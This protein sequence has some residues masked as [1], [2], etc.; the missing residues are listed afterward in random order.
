MPTGHQGPNKPRAVTSVPDLRSKTS[1]F[2]K[3]PAIHVQRFSRAIRASQTVV[4]PRGMVPIISFDG[5]FDHARIVKLIRERKA[6]LFELPQ[7]YAGKEVAVVLHLNNPNYPANYDL[8]MVFSLEEGWSLLAFLEK[9]GMRANRCI[10]TPEHAR[11]KGQIFADA[12]FRLMEEKENGQKYFDLSLPTGETDFNFIHSNL[13]DLLPLTGQTADEMAFGEL[14]FRFLV[15]P[16]GKIEAIKISD[17]RGAISEL[18]PKDQFPFLKTSRAHDSSVEIKARKTISN[19]ETLAMRQ[20]ELKFGLVHMGV[21]REFLEQG[22]GKSAFDF[23]QER[24]PPEM[25]NIL[26]NLSDEELNKW[27]DLLWKNPLFRGQAVTFLKYLKLEEM[28]EFVYQ[29]KTADRFEADLLLNMLGKS[30]QELRKWRYEL[31]IENINA[32]QITAFLM[33]LPATNTNMA[34]LLLVSAELPREEELEVVNAMKDKFPLLK[35]MFGSI[36]EEFGDDDYLD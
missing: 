13:A 26:L 11:L 12:R 24:T 2:F 34:S 28:L 14:Y 29:Y 1:G 17:R 22:D 7:Q 21:I 20:V 35:T 18:V 32:R 30:G 25:R 23:W 4:S 27:F 31:D 6:S 3:Y 9:D 16:N 5:T 8:A 15:L 36:I 19:N 33:I 10:F